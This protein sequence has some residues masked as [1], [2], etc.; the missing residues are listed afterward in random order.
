MMRFWPALALAALTASAAC[1]QEKFATGQGE[2]RPLRFSDSDASQTRF[3]KLDFL[4]GLEWRSD[5]ADFGGFSGMLLDDDGTITAI[6]DKAHWARAK[7]IFNPQGGLAAIEGLEIWRLYATETDFL[8]RPNTDA[9]A[10]TRDGDALLIAFE[11]NHRV[12]RFAGLGAPE[13]KLTG[14]PNLSRLRNNK[15]L[16]ALLKLPDGRLVMVAEEPPSDADSNDH[17]GWIMQGETAQRFRI[18]RAG[19][20]SVTDL[21]LGPDGETLY[22][23]ERRYSLF[24]GPGMRIRRFPLSD[25]SPGA[26]IVGEALI[27]IGAGHAVDNM[28]ALATRRG[29]SGETELLV[30]SDDNFSFRQR[31]LLLHFRVSDR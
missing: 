21:A 23:L 14:L 15:G 2:T 16:E 22:L 28:E 27:D 11:G 25:L 6:T 7:L 29:A 31:T 8:Q 13:E 24:G 1:A 17:V 20:Y 30:L 9:E 10:I 26:M 5:R 3:G 18:K 4:G 12:S 19:R